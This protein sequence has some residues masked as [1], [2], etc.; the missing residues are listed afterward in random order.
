VIVHRKLV[1]T[2]AL[3]G[4]YQTGCQEIE[5]NQRV[6]QLTKRTKIGIAAAQRR[7]NWVFPRF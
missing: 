3:V 2:V 4:F 7:F 5:M 1:L 6:R